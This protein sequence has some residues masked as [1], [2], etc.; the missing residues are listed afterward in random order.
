M[1]SSFSSDN[2]VFPFSTSRCEADSQQEIVIAGK[3]SASD[4]EGA[5]KHKHNGGPGRHLVA[6]KFY[7]FSNCQIF[8]YYI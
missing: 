2:P 1:P 7:F 6:G 5:S 3:R 8:A 4:R